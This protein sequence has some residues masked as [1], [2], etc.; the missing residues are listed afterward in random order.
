[1][2]DLNLMIC[3]PLAEY[4]DEES[5]SGSLAQRPA[6]L[7]GRVVGL[8]P[9]WRPSAVDL[10]RMVGT[11][12]SERCRTKAVVLE[13]AVAAGR[14]VKHLRRRRRR[15]RGRVERTGG[16]IAAQRAADERRIKRPA[17]KVSRDGAVALL[18]GI[19]LTVATGAVRFGRRDAGRQ[20][21]IDVLTE[22]KAVR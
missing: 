21:R 4:L 11:V 16:R 5:G 6:S 13:H 20:R 12:I 22:A 14:V 2:S 19:D 10:L 8:L 3:S 9:N 1:M 17:S 18:A 7:D 15:A